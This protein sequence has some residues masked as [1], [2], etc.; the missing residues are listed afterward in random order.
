MDWTRLH[1]LKIADPS[2]LILRLLE[3]DTLL[4]LKKISFSGYY[5][6]HHAILQFLSRTHTPLKSLTFDGINFCSL[7][8]TVS[9]IVKYHGL[10]LQT[11]VLKHRHTRSHNYYPY[12]YK[13]YRYPSD[14]FLTTTQLSSLRDSCPTLNTLEIDIET[15]AYW[16]YSILDTLTSFTELEHLVLRFEETKARNEY[17]YPTWDE[18]DDDWESKTEVRLVMIG[19]A[20]YLR[21]NKSGKPFDT[22]ETWVDQENILNSVD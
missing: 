1:T 6:D 14:A 5:A 20:N 11:L 22:L 17:M 13:P 16:N 12:S 7:D 4:S 15:S 18:D 10:T 21:K 2:S 8:E 19:L 9:T 3:G